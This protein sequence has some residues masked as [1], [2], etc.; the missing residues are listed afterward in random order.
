[1]GYLAGYRL[2][3]VES[4]EAEV[5]D[6]AALLFAEQARISRVAKSAEAPLAAERA[7]SDARRAGG[8]PG[9]RMLLGA[10]APG[11]SDT[12][13]APG[14]GPADQPGGGAAPAVRPLG[15]P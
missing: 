1:M 11:D 6:Q 5:E 7:V 10:P 8:L 12:D 9:I 4:L 15:R 2:A 3:R 13:A 14:G